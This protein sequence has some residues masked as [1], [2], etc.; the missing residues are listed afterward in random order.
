[1]WGPRVYGRGSDMY[2]WPNNF[3]NNSLRLSRRGM[4]D[5]RVY[6]RGSDMYTWPNNLL[7]NSSPQVGE[8]CE[9]HAYTGAGQTCIH[10]KI[11]I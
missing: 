11:I 10:G 6:G 1:M 5:P 9:F 2:T 7:N 3:S 4:R 8:G